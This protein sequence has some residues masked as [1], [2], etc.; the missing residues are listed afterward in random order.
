MEHA[1]RASRL[2]TDGE[3]FDR[4][5]AIADEHLMDPGEKLE[6]DE[7]LADLAARLACLDARERTVLTLRY[8]LGGQMPQ[9]LKEVGRKLGVTREWVRKI[10]Q[11]ALV[12]LQQMTPA[13]AEP[14]AAPAATT[15]G[16]GRKTRTRKRPAA[17]CM[18]L[19]TASA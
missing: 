12:K 4:I 14:A 3:G 13:T 2:G 6:R 8:G 11:K 1:L 17:P 15:A 10:E 5:A 16:P 19:Q 9:T 18:M 7:A